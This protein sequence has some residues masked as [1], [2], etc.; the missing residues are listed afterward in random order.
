LS[1]AYDRIDAGGIAIANHIIGHGRVPITALRDDRSGDGFPGRVEAVL[2]I[3][4]SAFV[5]F[6]ENGID[7]Y[8]DL[9]ALETDPAIFGPLISRVYPVIHF[10]AVRVRQPELVDLLAAAGAGYASSAEEPHQGGATGRATAAEA[11]QRRQRGGYIPHLKIFIENLKPQTLTKRS[12]HDLAVL[13]ENQVKA[14]QPTLE[15]PGTRYIANQIGKLRPKYLN[16][17]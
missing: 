16:P 15:L 1:E 13:F 4:D 12:D 7:A 2:A 14:Q 11:P 9:E 5:H 3:A 10:S 8:F 6:G 17:R